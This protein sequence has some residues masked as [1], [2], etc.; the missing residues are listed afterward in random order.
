MGRRI[1]VVGAGVIGLSVAVRL[2]EHGHVVDVLARD[3][4][5]ETTSALMTGLWLPAPQEPPPALDHGSPAR[6]QGPVGPGGSGT[7]GSGTGGSGTGG[8]GTGGLN[9]RGGAVGQ[10]ELIGLAELTEQVT[11]E[12]RVRRGER[13]SRWARS[14]LRELLALAT[15]PATGVR[16]A[17]GHLLHA[18]P[19]PPPEW[20]DPVADLVPLQA[21]TDPVPGYPFG[22]QVTLPIVD[23]PVYLTYLRNRLVRA[24]G[25]LTRLPL[26]VL[27]PRGLVV[28]CT[29]LSARALV[30][31]P[32]VYPQRRQLAFL[33]APEPLGWLCDAEASGPPLC[34]LPLDRQVT[35]IGG[36]T[37]HDSWDTAPDPDVARRLVQR[38]PSPAPGRRA[39]ARSPR[40]AVARA[41]RSPPGAGA[42]ARGG[43]PRSRRRPLLRSRRGRAHRELGMCG[44]RAGRGRHAGRGVSVCGPVRSAATTA[45]P[46]SRRRQTRPA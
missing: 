1:T 13:A 5:A 6:P 43:R 28:N 8:S 20:A 15:D 21:V 29:G 45:N 9:R 26:P 44:R 41:T 33:S 7:G 22:Y 40:R 37:E 38:G 23:S 14:T 4:P 18:R 36:T 16:A 25:T 39:G 42:P 19:A 31:D 2:A 27:P 32:A 3:L 12:Q 10:T 46:P 24:G 11:R 30:P 35:V 34:V 17:P